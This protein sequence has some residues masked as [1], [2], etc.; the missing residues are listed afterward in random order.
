MERELAGL[1]GL[2]DAERARVQE[3]ARVVYDYQL[4]K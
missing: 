3:G 4:K 1:P 2:T